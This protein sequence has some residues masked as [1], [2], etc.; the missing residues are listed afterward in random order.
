MTHTATPNTNPDRSQ[1]KKTIG[2]MAHSALY[3]NDGRAIPFH[4]E[5]LG[6]GRLYAFLLASRARDMGL[7]QLWIHPS[8]PGVL[9]W[10]IPGHAASNG[11][12]RWTLGGIADAKEHWHTCFQAGTYGAVDI[13]E[14]AK[15]T[16]A[17]WRLAPTPQDLLESL[18]IF[19]H[20]VGIEYRRSPGATGI[21]LIRWA[22]SG[23]RSLLIDLPGE[24]PPPALAAGTEQPRRWMRALTAEERGR[25]YLHSYDKN[26]MYVAACS[27]LPLGLGAPIHTRPGEGEW[28]R[29][30]ADCKHP[31]TKLPGYWRVR[32]AIPRDGTPRPAGLD[33]MPLPF[34]IPRQGEAQIWVTTPTLTLMRDMGYETCIT[35]AHVWPRHHRVLE[36]WYHAIRTARADLMVAAAGDGSVF[37]PAALALTVLKES[38]AAASGRL[39]SRLWD[40]TG[41]HLYRPDWRHL[42]IASANSV[43]YRQGVK[44][45]EAGYWPFALGTDAWYFASDE[46]DPVKAC[47]AALKLGD[48][49][50]AWK[51]KDGAVPLA[52]VLPILDRA[53][54]QPWAQLQTLQKALNAIRRGEAMPFDEEEATAQ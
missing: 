42:M 32:P 7:H 25:R 30:G 11:A 29:L 8:W 37:G 35:E 9:D 45:C 10:S 21:E 2:V 36:Q 40:R 6:D 39:G 1:G 22:H 44:C 23:S 28:E 14:V 50:G 15:D 18:N 43:V 51:V 54:R 3:I 53:A 38:Y 17:S 13:V 47:P 49:L 41:D 48:N 31:I 20:A 19:Q 5:H 34:P 33:H 4:S 16:R 46:P 26:G 12:G 27:S 52:D 24:V